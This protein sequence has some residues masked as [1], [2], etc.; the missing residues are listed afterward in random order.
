MAPLLGTT[1]SQLWRNTTP[2]AGAIHTINRDGFLQAQ[3]SPE[4]AAAR[5]IPELWDAVSLTIDRVK[6]KECENLFAHA[7]Y[8]A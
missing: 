3:G 5:S 4:K 2:G 8:D 1:T 6:P 7:G